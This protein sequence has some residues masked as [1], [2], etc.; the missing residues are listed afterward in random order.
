MRAWL[1]FTIGSVGLVAA[2]TNLDD[3]AAPDCT[4]IVSPMAI[5]A[6]TQGST[7]S[8]AI[9]APGVCAWAVESQAGWVSFTGPREGKGDGNVGYAIAAHEGF[10]YRYATVT[11]AGMSVSVT[12]PGNP[13]PP[14]CSYSVSPTTV[15]A[16]A[17][18][19]PGSVAVAAPDGC[20]WSAGSQA[21][22]ITITS[23]A[24]GSGSGAVGFLM[25]ANT[26]G[27]RSGSL[28]AAGHSISVSQAGSAPPPNCSYSI[29]PNSANFSQA[30]GIGTINV[31]AQAGCAWTAA[32]QQSWIT[33]LSGGSGS[34][35]GQVRYSVAPC[36]CNNDRNGRIVVA[37]RNFDVRQD[38]DDGK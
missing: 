37:G 34:G 14:V 26:A 25:A 15:S 5:E 23:G 30:G 31:T 3:L 29:S 13:L 35:N 4:Y 19:G 24:S 38:E 2:C 11:V 33:I 9:K 36:T 20:A 22:W 6:A 8:L 1:A 17:A 28:A 16:P 18:G 10:D 7:G 12:Q 27:A 21:S 32:P